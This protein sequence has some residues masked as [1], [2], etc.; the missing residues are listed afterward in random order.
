[1][2]SSLSISTNFFPCES[3]CESMFL[4]YL[5][6][7]YVIHADA[8]EKNSIRAV[9]DYILDT[10][11][12]KEPTERRIFDF[13]KNGIKVDVKIVSSDSNDLVKNKDDDNFPEFPVKD[14]GKCIIDL[15]FV[16]VKKRF[17]Q[18]LETIRRLDEITVFGQDVKLV[19]NKLAYSNGRSMT[20][21]NNSYSVESSVD[22]FFDSFTL[23]ITLPRWNKREKN[24]IDIMM[25]KAL[26]EEGCSIKY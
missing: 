7:T 21:N 13:K 15:S 5:L 26:V 2:L 23:R 24:Q 20:N 11:L 14:I 8:Y 6:I 10:G 4:L 3:A 9:K 12:Q 1:M 22:D 17:I 25:D 16:C 18:F 19:K